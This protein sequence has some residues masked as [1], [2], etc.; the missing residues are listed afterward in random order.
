MKIYFGDH[1]KQEMEN[2]EFYL[3][4]DQIIIHEN[5]TTDSFNFDVCLLHTATDIIISSK[6][7]GGPDVQIACL[8]NSP[9]EHGKACWVGGW[10][11]TE[12]KGSTSDVL[13]SVGVNIFSDD[14]CRLHRISSTHLI[15]SQ[16]FC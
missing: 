3:E 7:S 8:P 1:N 16:I 10:G 14:Y 12:W 13:M 15:L 9:A 11:T 6:L 5:Y 2:G 4:A